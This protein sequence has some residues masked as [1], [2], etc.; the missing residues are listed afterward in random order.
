MLRE[1][2]M[3]IVCRGKKRE[4]EEGMQAESN[5]GRERQTDRHTVR[6]ADKIKSMEL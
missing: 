3:S 6:Q 2:G 4:D 5:R 1:A